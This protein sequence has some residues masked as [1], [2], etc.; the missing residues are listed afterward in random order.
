MAWPLLDPLAREEMVTDQCLTGLDSHELRVQVAT[1]GA[2]R[3]EDPMRIAH[4]LEA[5]EGDETSRHASQG[6]TQTRFTEEDEGYESDVTRITDQI[7]AKL[8]PEL[9]PSR[10]PKRRSPTP[11][12]QKVCSA[13]RTTTLPPQKDTSTEQKREKS[14]GT[15]R[16]RSPSTDRSRSCSRDGPPQCFK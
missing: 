4:P 8:G 5:V 1:T 13:E 6:H 16:G 10:D 7:L 3:I 9:R 15:E 11:R 12:P 2:R 14:K